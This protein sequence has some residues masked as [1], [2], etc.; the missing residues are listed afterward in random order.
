MVTSCEQN[1][2]VKKQHLSSFTLSPM[3][4]LK[5]VVTALQDDGSDHILFMTENDHIM[6]M[7]VCTLFLFM[8]I[9]GSRLTCIIVGKTKGH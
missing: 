7:F 5:Q 3:L 6:A 9:I 4:P 1:S 2:A 8:K